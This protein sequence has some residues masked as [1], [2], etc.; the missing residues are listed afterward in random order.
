[1]SAG[2]RHGLSYR[3]SAE[4]CRRR[5]DVAVDEVSKA[6]WLTFAQEWTKL[7]A[8]AE[9]AGPRRIQVDGPFSAKSS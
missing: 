7:A 1:V 2:T 8:E 4:E 3:R 6:T 5:A 9:K